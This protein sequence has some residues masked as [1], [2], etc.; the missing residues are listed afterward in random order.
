MG[1]NCLMGTG[2][3]GGGNILELVATWILNATVHFRLVNFMLCE[4]HLKFLLLFFKSARMSNLLVYTSPP[5]PGMLSPTHSVCPS[6][7][8]RSPWL[9]ASM[10]LER[11]HW[12]KNDL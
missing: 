3:G 10:Q 4:F 5:D 7:Y 9:I 12:V 2:F 8:L 11:K 1:H 6:Q